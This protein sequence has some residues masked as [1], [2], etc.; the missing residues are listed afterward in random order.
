VLLTLG[1]GGPL[2]FETSFTGGE[3][4]ARRLAFEAPKIL[5]T[6]T[7]TLSMID[8]EGHE[9]VDTMAVSVNQHSYRLL[10]WLLFVP[11]VAAAL[12]VAL[13]VRIADSRSDGLPLRF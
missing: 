7:L 11:F 10:K 13:A 8:S 5:H 2:L 9:Y 4:G 6:A 3:S 12:A 1:P